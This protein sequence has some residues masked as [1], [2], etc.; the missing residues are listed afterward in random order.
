MAT[1]EGQA[2]MARTCNITTDKW[3]KNSALL[4]ALPYYLPFSARCPSR[5]TMTLRIN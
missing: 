1:G 5:P 2:R 4:N 3:P